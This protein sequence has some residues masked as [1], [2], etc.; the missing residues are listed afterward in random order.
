MIFPFQWGDFQVSAVRFF[1]GEYIYRVLGGWAPR[2]G[3]RIRGEE[4]HGDRFRP[5]S[6]ILPQMGYPS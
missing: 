6:W 1:S 3:P 2:T 4:N 5:L